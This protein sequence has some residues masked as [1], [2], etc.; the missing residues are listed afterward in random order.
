MTRVACQPLARASKRKALIH[1]PT[2][3][4]LLGCDVVRRTGQEPDA[5]AGSARTTGLHHSHEPSPCPPSPH[6]MSG[7]QVLSLQSHRSYTREGKCQ[8]RLQ[9]CSCVLSI[10]LDM[11]PAC[12][13]CR[14]AL[15]GRSHDADLV[16]V[17]LGFLWARGARPRG[18]M[19]A[20]GVRNRIWR[21]ER[22]LPTAAT[23]RRWYRCP[24]PG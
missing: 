13:E 10:P 24:R 23:H 8:V 16:C 18:R 17:P 7:L 11:T 6:P 2:P 1:S 15:A 3:A 12:G 19:K 21:I 9:Y 20:A 5:E 4:C 14:G 22:S